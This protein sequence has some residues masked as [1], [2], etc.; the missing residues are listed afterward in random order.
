MF[1]SIYKTTVRNL[2]RAP[3]FWMMFVVFGF[4]AIELVIKGSY[5]YYDFELNELIMDTDPR[6]V[7]SYTTYVQ[8]ASNTVGTELLLYAMPVFTIVSVVL[9]LN[10][11]YGDNFYEIEKA[12]GTK[13]TQ[14]LIG[15][16]SALVTVNYIVAIVTAFFI[17]HPYVITRGG[18]EGMDV[19]TYIA[20]STVRLMRH[21]I[22]RAFPALLFYIGFTYCVGS[23]FRSGAA[24]AICSIGYMIFYVVAR[25]RLQFRVHPFYFDYLSPNPHKLERYLHFYDSDPYQ[26]DSTVR[27]ANTNLTK[28]A[29]CVCILVG[30][31][32][33]YSTIAYLRTRKRDR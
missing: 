1:F 30:L 10:R 24:A 26:F 5:G 17:L 6:F 2:V 21:V 25:S 33:L 22:F 8:H 19:W 20:D 28:A 29:I 15:R 14:Y 9:I 7:L 3:I 27:M 32:A 23:L 4:V 31:G 13:P 16:L 18:V 11:D 12:A